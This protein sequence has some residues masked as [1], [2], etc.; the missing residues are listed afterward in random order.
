LGPQRCCA[1]ERVDSRGA[2]DE[3]GR[4][5]P[6]VNAE[7]E[8]SKEDEIQITGGWKREQQKHTSLIKP[9]LLYKGEE[10]GNN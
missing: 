4:C 2:R 7:K 6:P 10:K 5:P 9:Q 3:A 1:K 8:A